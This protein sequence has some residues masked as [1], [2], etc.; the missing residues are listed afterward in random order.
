MTAAAGPPALPNG[1]GRL[2]DARPLGGG[3]ICQVWAG[4]LDDGSPVAVKQA[5]YDV[6][7]EVDGLRALDAAG[8]PVPA[9]LGAD[10]DVLVLRHVSGDPAWRDLGSR[11]AAMHRE[12]G[13]GRFGWHRDNLLGRAVQAGGWSDDWPTFFAEHRLR[14]LLTADA[15][16]GVVRARI[17][18][19][20]TGPLPDLL[21][22]HTPAPSLVHGDLWSGNIIDGHWLIDPAVWMA[23]RELEM[24]FTTMFGSVPEAFFAGYD[25]AWPLP[26]GAA[27]RR[28]ALQLYH[29]LIHVWHF[30]AS[31]VG[32]VVDRLD[33]L[34]WT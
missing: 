30:G 2:H 20:I 11:I 22:A 7:V 4:T 16:P 10:G 18:R 24:A 23:D 34:G 28:P 8:A 15:L 12:P 1:L 29:L 13:A 19:A 32:G 33:R 9:V 26:D 3:M 27:R 6:D 31:Y 25:A 5:P 21:G 14:P 17:E